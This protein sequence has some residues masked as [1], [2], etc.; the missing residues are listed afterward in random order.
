M[1]NVNRL[2][3]DTIFDTVAISKQHES[4]GVAWTRNGT[5]G[6]VGLLWVTADPDQIQGRVLR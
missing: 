2:V 6:S 5:A 1:I 4:G 3:A